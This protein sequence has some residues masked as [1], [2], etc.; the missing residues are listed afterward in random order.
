MSEIPCLRRFLWWISDLQIRVE[1]WLLDRIAGP[2]P[3]DRGGSHPGVTDGTAASHQTFPGTDIDGTERCRRT[4]FPP[5]ASGEPVSRSMKL[6]IRH[7]PAY[8][9]SR[10]E[11]GE[12]PRRQIRAAFS[13]TLVP[14][15]I[16]RDHR[17]SHIVGQISRQRPSTRS[18][19]S[20]RKATNFDLCWLCRNAVRDER[21]RRL[22]PAN[23][24][25]S[26]R[27]E[28]TGPIE[29]PKSR[30]GLRHRRR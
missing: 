16:D 8:R 15:A 12:Q 10:G 28:P 21:N 18:V 4:Y 26:N 23:P 30:P 1:F 2:L 25:G 20:R 27:P 19:P 11:P 9:M 17:A 3:G 13:R 6:C 22:H 7:P 29:W 5:T 14:A 24:G